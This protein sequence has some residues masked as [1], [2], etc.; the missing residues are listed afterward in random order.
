MRMDRRL[1]TAAK[2]GVGKLTKKMGMSM[3][4]MTMPAEAIAESEWSKDNKSHVLSV[5]PGY[6]NT[7]ERGV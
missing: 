5:V 6:S 2:K 7:E 1:P 3:G 4:E